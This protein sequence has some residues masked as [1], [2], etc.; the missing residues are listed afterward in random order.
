MNSKEQAGHGGASMRQLG[1]EVL[2]MALHLAHQSLIA[3]TVLGWAFC[4]TRSLHLATMALVGVSWLGFGLIHGLGYCLLTDLQ[5]TLKER[6]GEERP[7]GGYMKFLADRLS[8]R[9]LDAKLIDAVTYSTCAVCTAASLL[10]IVSE[11]A[12]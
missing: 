7:A 5:W 9:D 3:F 6:M 4:E 11:G 12:C 2:N 8:G 10:L 1:Y